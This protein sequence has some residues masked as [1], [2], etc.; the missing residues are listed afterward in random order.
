MA[1]QALPLPEGPD[2]D[3]GHA[4]GQKKG[5]GTLLPILQWGEKG[6]IAAQSPSLA[7]IKGLDQ[8]L[9]VPGLLWLYLTLLWATFVDQSDEIVDFLDTVMTNII[10]NGILW[11]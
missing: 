1:V 7:Q 4:Q 9:S 8:D 2:P 11:E 10:N 6:L 5:P 3:P